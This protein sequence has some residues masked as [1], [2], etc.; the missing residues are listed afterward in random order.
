MSEKESVK[1]I[2]CQRVGLPCDR[3]KE[4]AEE[5]KSKNDIHRFLLFNDLYEKCCESKKKKGSN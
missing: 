1:Q 5:Y 4:K 3:L 2:D